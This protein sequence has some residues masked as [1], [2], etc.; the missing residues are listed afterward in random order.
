[1]SSVEKIHNEIHLHLCII[2]QCLGQCK[3]R[4]HIFSCSTLATLSC[5]LMPESV[6]S[7]AWAMLRAQVCATGH[8]QT[9]TLYPRF[10]ICLNE[11]CIHGVTRWML[12]AL[13]RIRWRKYVH[14][15]LLTTQNSGRKKKLIKYTALFVLCCRK[16]K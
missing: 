1:M 13:P 11:P 10:V 2:T 4:L 15:N 3:Q 14:Q 9:N 7:S 5:D 12:Q 6:R 16:K 8:S